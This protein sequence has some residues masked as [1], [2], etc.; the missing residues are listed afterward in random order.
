MT[1]LIRPARAGEGQALY[2]VTAAAIR[3]LAAG[4]YAPAQIGAW[5][6][7]RDAAQYEEVIAAGTVRVAE[8]GGVIFGFVDTAPGV[9]TRLFVRPEA[10][11]AG[12]GRRLLEIGVA[13][14]W[15]EERVRLEATLNAA[16]FYARCGFVEISRGIYAHPR[17]GLPVEVVNMELRLTP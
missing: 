14:A 16:P 6:D 2:D 12:L 15:L 3:G 9:V 5:M 1:L 17:G 13:A 8:A 7:G 10:A 4:H 11:G